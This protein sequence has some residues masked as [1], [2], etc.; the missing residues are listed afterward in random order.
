MAELQVSNSV[1]LLDDGVILN[2]SRFDFKSINEVA[3][4]C[5]SSVYK[6]LSS[7]YENSVNSQPFEV[8]LSGWSYG[9][10]VAAEVARLLTLSGKSKV[11]SLLIFD[12]PLRAS[13]SE[14]RGQKT[15]IKLDIHEIDTSLQYRTTKHFRACTDLLKQ[16]QIRTICPSEPLLSCFVWD[17]RPKISEYDCGLAAAQE[18]TVGIAK[19]VTVEG[20]HWN[21]LMGPHSLNIA[22]II[23]HA[24]N[25]PNN[26]CSDGEI[27]Q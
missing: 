3:E 1:Y 6:I 14:T 2:S 12:S 26:V 18:L 22:A 23:K 13:I 7:V 11:L 19:R 21:M 9:G 25:S 17:I 20:N 10:V 16:Y 5:L 15:D 24:I 27:L 4:A 8:I